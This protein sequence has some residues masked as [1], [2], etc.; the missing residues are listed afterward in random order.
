LNLDRVT[1]DP[2]RSGSDIE[3]DEVSLVASVRAALT[4]PLAG[5]LSPYYTSTANFARRLVHAR[6]AGLVL[7]NRLYQHDVDLET[8]LVGADVTMM[9]SALLR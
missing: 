4:I 3:D 7:F 6:A 9:T 2:D 5:K 1:A 8:L